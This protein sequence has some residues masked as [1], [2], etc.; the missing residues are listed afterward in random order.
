MPNRKRTDLA[1]IILNVLLMPCRSDSLFQAAQQ[2]L[3]LVACVQVGAAI[4]FLGSN[5]L[6]LLPGEDLHPQVRNIFESLLPAQAD[7]RIQLRLVVTDRI[8]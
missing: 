8:P 2:G 4:G 6:P 1:T 7:S 5:S 3:S